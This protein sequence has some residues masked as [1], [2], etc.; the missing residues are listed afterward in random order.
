MSPARS[1]REC[2][3][4]YIEKIDVNAVSLVSAMRLPIGYARA[5]KVLVTAEHGDTV[6]VVCGDPLDTA[7]LDDVRAAFGKSVRVS[8]ASAETVVDAMHRVYERQDT[9]SDLKE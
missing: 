3:L 5:H 8:V 7:A 6:D 2:G 9:T 1:P 4:P